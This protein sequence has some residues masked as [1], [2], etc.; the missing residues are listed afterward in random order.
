ML[1]K[2]WESVL[3]IVHHH[4]PFELGV[5]ALIEYCC[6]HFLCY[7]FYT[8]CFC[9]VNKENWWMI[10]ALVGFPAEP[11][12]TINNS[13]EPADPMA[14]RIWSWPGSRHWTRYTSWSSKCRK[15]LFCQRCAWYVMTRDD[16][17]LESVP[18]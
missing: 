5:P 11:G 9:H 17:C 14:S 6:D 1:L 16:W 7:T 12:P 18:P 2:S 4:L 13:S 10:F 8:V 3:H 15:I